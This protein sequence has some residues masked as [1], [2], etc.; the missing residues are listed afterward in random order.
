MKTAPHTK[1]A[2]VG[3][4]ALIALCSLIFG[5]A[6]CATTDR[7]D[8]SAP[9]S[10]KAPDHEATA[11]LNDQGTFPEL[12]VPADLRFDE[13]TTSDGDKG[14][15]DIDCCVIKDRNGDV[16][17]CYRMDS[18]RLNNTLTCNHWGGT[19]RGSGCGAYGD[20][21]PPVGSCMPRG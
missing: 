14:E 7:Q 13:G 3:L 1:T 8:D 11:E 18:G 16:C 20:C 19:K 10:D 5:A 6:A 21:N 15:K 12:P 17:A 2:R 9:T 4:T